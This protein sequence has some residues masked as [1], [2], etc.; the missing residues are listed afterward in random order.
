MGGVDDTLTLLAGHATFLLLVLPVIGA[1]LVLVSALWGADVARR[2]ALTNVLFSVA[3]VVAMLAR[4]EPNPTNDDGTPRRFQMA[5]EAAFEFGVRGPDADSATSPATGLLRGVVG[6]DGLSLWF[7]ALIP[8]VTLAAVHFSPNENNAAGLLSLILLLE[9]ALV[10]VFAGLNV[11]FF[12]VCLEVSSLLF[13]L[14]VGFRGA[15][16]H[17]RGIASLAA[18]Q[19]A[20]GLPVFLGLTML[21]SAHL[22]VTGAATGDTPTLTFSLPVLVA[23]LRASIGSLPP[24]VSHY[25]SLAET[26]LFWS[27]MLG[28]ATTAALFPFHGRFCKATP[29]WPMSAAVTAYGAFPAVGVYGV[30][31]LVVPIC[32]S[33]VAASGGLLIGLLLA[34]AVY[35]GL[36]AVGQSNLKRT[37]AYAAAAHTGLTMAAALSTTAAGFS[38]AV[39]QLVCRLAA[40]GLLAA[41]LPVL[42]ARYGTLEIR[43][44]G[45]LA[46]RFPGIAGVYFL[47]V[48]GLSGLP[49]LCGFPALWLTIGGFAAAVEGVA[50]PLAA[51]AVHGL[52]AWALLSAGQRIF[53]GPVRETV[54]DVGTAVPFQ[55]GDGVAPQFAAT[56]WREADLL[57][58]APLVVVLVGL[59]LAPQF[60]ADRLQPVL[61]HTTAKRD[62]A[63]AMQRGAGR[64]WAAGSRQR[65]EV[66]P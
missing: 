40:F 59:G 56:D 34:G 39:L 66:R 25:W 36:L 4:F 62:D 53:W 46:K 54:R 49:G 33:S 20:G 10:G 58:I 52:L 2:T 37:V 55:T 24:S 5:S 65:E 1:I 31:R 14:I 21:V 38:G 43:A 35:C 44:H 60:V 9:A 47:A 7:V 26:L 61:P 16:E 63:T 30:L 57:A 13:Q 15:P 45:G 41:I 12:A 18:W 32:E 64:L 28:F 6:V 23:E 48:L 8:L 51:L 42:A 3:V 22:W 50:A 19:I 29:P 17:R 27:L 11:I